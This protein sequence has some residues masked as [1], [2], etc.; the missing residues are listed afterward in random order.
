MPPKPD[1]RWAELLTPE[2]RVREVRSGGET[3]PRVFVILMHGFL[4]GRKIT[5]DLI[6]ITIM[7]TKNP[8]PCFSRS[9]GRKGTSHN[10]KLQT[11]SNNTVRMKI[12]T[13]ILTLA[14]VG[15][16]VE[17]KG[18]AEARRGDHNP[19][20]DVKDQ[21]PHHTH[22]HTVPS[23]PS[24]TRTQPRIVVRALSPLHAQ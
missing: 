24:Y 17:S 6:M 10:Q 14:L 8:I 9:R 15:Q 22:T 12:I 13:K 19:T 11:K 2:C 4:M 18:N 21:R 5:L 16:V 23:I 7:T 1:S 20:S 3:L